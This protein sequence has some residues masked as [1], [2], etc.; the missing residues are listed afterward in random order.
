ML[1]QSTGCASFICVLDQWICEKKKTDRES[2][3]VWTHSQCGAAGHSAHV[4][5][6]WARTP[7]I[8]GTIGH[9]CPLKHTLGGFSER[10]RSCDLNTQKCTICLYVFYKALS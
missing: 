8:W 3:R 2:V 7:L 10:K 1:H 4:I 9:K 5:A 6:I